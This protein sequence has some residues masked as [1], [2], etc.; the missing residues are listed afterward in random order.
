[1]GN[2]LQGNQVLMLGKRTGTSG[3]FTEAQAY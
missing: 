1:M 2:K 3:G